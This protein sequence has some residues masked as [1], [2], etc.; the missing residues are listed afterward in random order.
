MEIKTFNGVL[1]GKD[2]HCLFLVR[3]SPEEDIFVAYETK[4]F[5]PRVFREYDLAI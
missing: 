1:E 2:R 4:V 5:S 3:Y